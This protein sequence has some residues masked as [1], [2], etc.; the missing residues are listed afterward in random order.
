MTKVVNS[1]RISLQVRATSPAGAGRPHGW[2][3]GER[4]ARR[5]SAPG[6]GRARRRARGGGGGG[7]AAA[8]GRGPPGGG[9]RGGGGGGGAAGGRWGLCRDLRRRARGVSR[10]RGF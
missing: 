9:R 5:R 7:G 6:P 2:R 8:R 4:G 1:R 3:A 10:S